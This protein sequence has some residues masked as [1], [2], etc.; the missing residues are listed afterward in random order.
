MSLSAGAVTFLS[1]RD[2]EPHKPASG[3]L[4]ASPS[5]PHMVG[6]HVR[7]LGEE[8]VPDA[9]G[10][11]G[12]NKAV[13][14]PNPRAADNG[15]NVQLT[16]ITYVTPHIINFSDSFHTIIGDLILNANLVLF[17]LTATNPRSRSPLRDSSH[18]ASRLRQRPAPNVPCVSRIELANPL[19]YTSFL[20]SPARGHFPCFEP[21]GPISLDLPLRPDVPGLS[22]PPSRSL[23]WP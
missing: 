10:H 11:V 4:R 7:G 8:G 3:S 22:R 13:S 6:Q 2:Q 21:R 9:L 1:P 12:R 5:H 16:R 19:T 18:S 14:F 17:L 20:P 23:K 15:R